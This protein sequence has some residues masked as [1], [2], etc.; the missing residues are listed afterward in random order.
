MIIGCE[1]LNGRTGHEAGRALLKR[2]YTEHFGGE[3]PE[4]QIADRGKPYFITGDIHFSISHTKRRVFCVLSDW[5]VGIDA[6]EMEREG[7][8]TLAAKTLSAGE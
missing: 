5:E 1:E 3:I 8:P 6:E 4:I 7:K 2:M